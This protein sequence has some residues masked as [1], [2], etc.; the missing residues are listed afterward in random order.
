MSKIINMLKRLRKRNAILRNGETA[1]V[2]PI[3]S[4]NCQNAIWLFNVQ[5]TYLDF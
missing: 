2:S 3:Y 1:I 4:E 5:N